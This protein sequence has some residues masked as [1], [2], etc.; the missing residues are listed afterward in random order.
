LQVIHSDYHFIVIAKPPNQLSVPSKSGRLGLSVYQELQA[1]YPEARCVHRLDYET[2]G[3]MV[4]A[5]GK[6]AERHLFEQFR[7]RL[8]HKEYQAI[9]VGSPPKNSGCIQFPLSPEHIHSP[10]MTYLHSNGKQA[11][12]HWHVNQRFAEH[13]IA[14]L[15]PETGRRHQLRVHL[16]AIGSPIV[17]DPLY[18]TVDTSLSRM[19]LHA[20]LLS[21]LHPITKNR[22]VFNSASNFI[23]KIQ[24]I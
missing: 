12:T 16:M 14:N 17:N 11:T 4:F 9:C 13:W 7:K 23:S 3:L 18:G 5:R 24:L 22:L 19:Y 6:T 1:V 8:V 2:S 15:K 20:T 21:F 10:K